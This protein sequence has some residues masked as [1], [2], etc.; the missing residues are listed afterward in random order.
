MPWVGERPIESGGIL[1]LIWRLGRLLV[2]TLILGVGLYL[3]SPYL[4]TGVG[5]YLITEHPLAKADLVLV[6]SGENLLRVPEG[7]RICREGYAPKILL[8]NELKERG[9]DDLL[10]LG[11][12]IPD[13]QERAIALLEELHFPRGE[14][15]TIQERA[16]STR[17]EMQAV[18]RFLKSHPVKS[19][20][21]V[22]S[23]SH[24]T[25]AYKIFSTGLGSGI[26]LIM[27]PVPS[28]PF[29]P[30]RW[31]QDRTDAKDVLHEY[32]ALADFWRLRLWT[33]VVGEF[34]AAPP[35]VTVR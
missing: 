6:L 26:R 18:A 12:R 34:A 9:S 32:E 33:T 17:S 31:W 22:T 28:D 11:I 29:D 5:R 21:I 27:H 30:T 3:G 13:S 2:V 15:L 7:A 25:R 1:R 24:T 8:T 16:D 20:I 14:I 23:K 35:P 4:L 10:R 19:M